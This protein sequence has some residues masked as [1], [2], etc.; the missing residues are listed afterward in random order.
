MIEAE[1]VL[2][3]SA[4]TNEERL[5]A[6]EQWAILEQKAKSENRDMAYLYAQYA[7]KN[8]PPNVKVLNDIL[9]D[10]KVPDIQKQA[11]IA[12]Q[13]NLYKDIELATP[14]LLES[15]DQQKELIE[16]MHTE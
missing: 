4:L 1:R 6:S 7:A 15:L 10:P 14:L 5:Y 13:N 11:L 2:F 3:M 9:S 12:I 8:G 16:R